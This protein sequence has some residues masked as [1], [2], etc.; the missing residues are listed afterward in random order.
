M[1]IPSLIRV[2]ATGALIGL[3]LPACGAAP[4]Q[5]GSD[6]VQTSSQPEEVGNVQE[7]VCTGSDCSTGA[8]ESSQKGAD[9][10]RD[11]SADGKAKGRW[12]AATCNT[13]VA[14]NCGLTKEEC[15]KYVCD[16]FPVGICSAEFKTYAQCTK[17]ATVID[18]SNWIY[19]GCV[20]ELQALQACVNNGS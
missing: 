1:Q 5:P 14:A 13:V 11:R 3:V 15:H 19:P 2:A 16:A 18:C 9:R 6:Q 8:E 7:A 12:C 17:K 4:D 20:A 10:G